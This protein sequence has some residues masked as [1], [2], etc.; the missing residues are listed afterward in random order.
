MADGEQELQAIM[1][2]V[3]RPM[4]RSIWRIRVSGVENV[5]ATDGAILTPN[6]TSVI[7]SFFL[8]AVAPRPV[9]FVGKAEYLDDWKTRKLFP[10]LG[11][12]PIDRSGGDASQRALDTAAQVL[13]SGDLFAIYPEGNRSRTGF[14]HKGHTGAARLSI[15]T[16]C[17][18]VPVGIKGARSIQPPDQ[19]VP[20]V[21]R[22]VEI[23]FGT[24]IHPAASDSVSDQR[25]RLRQIT[26]EV[27]FEIRALTGQDYVNEYAGKTPLPAAQAPHTTVSPEMPERR[28]SADVLKPVPA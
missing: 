7:D 17:P 10:A 15:R 27:M 5:P 3:L 26:D 14:L 9:S 16:G 2:A 19:P 13:E 22:P 1:R 23:H 12:I 25:L 18:I 11:M 4:F 24:P 20:N 28:S 8:P 6:H 21:F